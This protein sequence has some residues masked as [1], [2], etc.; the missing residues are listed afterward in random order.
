MAL[1]EHAERELKLAGFFKKDDGG[2][3]DLYDGMLGPAILDLVKAFADQGHSGM[4]ASIVLRVFP[5]VAN[6]KPLTPLTYGP[7]EWNDI[8]EEMYSRKISQNK[9]NSSI[10]TEDGG[11]TH[12]SVND[13]HPHSK[14][15][16]FKRW[17]KRRMN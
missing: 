14:L 2:D 3:S 13:K 15:N 7:E 16:K 5:R 10:F 8:S 6:F 4:S 12:Y 17:L 9:R 1:V 11:K